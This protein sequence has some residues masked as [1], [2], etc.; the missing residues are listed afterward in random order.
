[1]E[2]TSGQRKLDESD[3]DPM[4]NSIATMGDSHSRSSSQLESESNKVMSGR[5][6]AS[7]QSA[8]INQIKEIEE[9]MEYRRQ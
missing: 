1:M 7:C 9:E 8:E 2:R 3:E 6:R 4:T 5:D